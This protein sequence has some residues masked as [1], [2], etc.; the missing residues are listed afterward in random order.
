MREFTEQRCCNAV[1]LSSFFF[2][3]CLLLLY[4]GAG[5][6]R[7]WSIILYR[8][9]KGRRLHYILLHSFFSHLLNLVPLAS[10]VEGGSSSL[11]DPKFEEPPPLASRALPLALEAVPR[12]L[13]LMLPISSSSLRCSLCR[14]QK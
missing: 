11:S 13:A 6:K 7:K 10:F 12:L 2:Y 1:Y 3:F 5:K 9:E 14:W 8:R 4:D